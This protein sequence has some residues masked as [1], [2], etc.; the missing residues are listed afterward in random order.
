MSS[1]YTGAGRHYTYI[2]DYNI[3]ASS[4]TAPLLKAT[5]SN[6]P[7]SNQ[8]FNLGGT[9]LPSWYTT[10]VININYVVLRIPGTTSAGLASLT[11]YGDE[12][13]LKVFLVYRS[14]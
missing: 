8:W 12:G 14:D 10:V 9:T 2:L 5:A 4:R 3:T 7:S 6:G 13:V 1:G 11:I